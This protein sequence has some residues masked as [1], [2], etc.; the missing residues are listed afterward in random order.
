MRLR[1]FKK[2]I[3]AAL[4]ISCMLH[5]QFVLAENLE[6][7]YKPD[8]NDVRQNAVQRTQNYTQG[9]DLTHFRNQMIEGFRSDDGVT[10]GKIFGSTSTS[11][12]TGTDCGGYTTSSCGLACCGQQECSTICTPSRT[13]AHGNKFTCTDPIQT[14]PCGMSCCGAKDC[15]KVCINYRFDACGGYTVTTG[16]W[17]P[18]A[19]GI[20]C[21]GKNNCHDVECG[22]N[23]TTNGDFGGKT[24]IQ[25]CGAADCALK[26]CDGHVS[27]DSKFNPS[28]KNQ[29]C[30]GAD[31]CHKVECDN[32]VVTSTPTQQQVDCCGYDDCHYKHCEGV[33]ETT[34][35]S[36]QKWACCGKSACMNLSL[37]VAANKSQ[38][39]GND[40][41]VATAS[42][43][44]P[45]EKCWW[46]IEGDGSIVSGDQSFDS[47]GRARATVVG[48]TPYKTQ[49]VIKI[50][51]NVPG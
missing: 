48:K 15:A 51:S 42:G 35:D 36:G 21:C 44:I 45:G 9:V 25:C 49:I 38:I 11:G 2:P 40:T 34:N 5:T 8:A 7:T 41:F 46:T 14:S 1:R 30:C 28:L 17:N 13:S 10:K 33:F 32:Y 43:G 23:T 26:E 3:L 19:K 18:K 39:T 50:H 22:F 47:A 37:M 4:C 16:Q 27:A 20:K 12:S 24:G 31:S 6:E 29:P